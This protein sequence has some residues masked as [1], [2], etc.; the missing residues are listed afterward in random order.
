MRFRILLIPWVDSLFEFVSV[1]VVSG[2]TNNLNAV[3]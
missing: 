3:L 2:L 1:L